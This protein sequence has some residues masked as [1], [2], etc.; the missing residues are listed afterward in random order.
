M[1]HFAALTII[2]DEHR[3]LAAVLHALRH[4]VKGLVEQGL[5][6]DF[7]V[8][9]SLLFYIDAY[10]E[11]LHHPKETEH[12]FKTLRQR[13]PQAA[14]VLDRLD[15]DHERGEAAILKLEHQLLEYEM[16]GGSRLHEFALAV[17]QFCDRYMQHMQLEEQEVLPLARQALLP[18]D[19]ARIN[20]EFEANRD[21]LTGHKPEAEYEALL[22]RIV[23]L[24]PPP[25][26]LG[27]E[28]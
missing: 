14:E 17:D 19:W 26:G 7:Q 3:A 8:L 10:P 23:N 27:P 11:R 21:P 18:E 24:L 12:L 9:R 28:R 22:Q 20:A 25:L 1:N 6:P 13:L 4:T 15:H 2:R 5:A 16:L